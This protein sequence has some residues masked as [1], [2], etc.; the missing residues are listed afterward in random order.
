[1]KPG[2]DVMFSFLGYDALRVLIGIDPNYISDQEIKRL[3]HLINL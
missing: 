3:I 2:N 1:M